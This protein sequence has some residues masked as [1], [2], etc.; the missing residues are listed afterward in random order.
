MQWSAIA[1]LQAG[2][3]GS[4]LLIAGSLLPSF[5]VLIAGAVSFGFAG[6]SVKVCSDTLV[7]Q[8][9]PD[10]HLGRVFALF[11]MFVNVC[12]VAGIVIMAVVSP[13][14][15]QTP[16]LYAAAGTGLIL[17]AWW[18]LRFRTRRVPLSS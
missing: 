11:D 4:G 10:D 2:V 9:I 7:Q 13:T 18:Y 15:G 6:Q 12:L 8:H 5:G 16:L 17:T 14:S 3:L 1:L